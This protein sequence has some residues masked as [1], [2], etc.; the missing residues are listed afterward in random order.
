MKILR[1]EKVS[2]KIQSI[3]ASSFKFKAQGGKCFATIHYRFAVINIDDNA[4][5]STGPATDSRQTSLLYVSSGLCLSFC[6]KGTETLVEPSLQSLCQCPAFGQRESCHAAESPPRGLGCETSHDSESEPE[7][8]SR[9]ISICREGKWS[10]RLFFCL[11][12]SFSLMRAPQT[13]CSSESSSSGDA[14]EFSGFSGVFSCVFGADPNLVH[15]L[16]KQMKNKHL[17]LINQ[18]GLRGRSQRTNS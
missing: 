2:L 8:L 14:T 17:F 7:L 15:K 5:H 13:L 18:T 9:L 12:C 3:S 4:L 6:R 11:D 10:K 16:P 1:T